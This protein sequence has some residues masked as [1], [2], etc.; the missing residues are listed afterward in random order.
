MLSSNEDIFSCVYR[1][2]ATTK[3][4]GG[5]IPTDVPPFL[6]RAFAVGDLV[7][8]DYYVTGCRRK[9]RS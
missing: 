3:P 4:D 6:Y 7:K 2:A 1:E 9:R 8:I 5:V